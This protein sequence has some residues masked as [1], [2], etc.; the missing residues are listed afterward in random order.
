MIQN[1]R[2]ANILQNELWWG[3]NWQAKNWSLSL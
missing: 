1:K 3:G 2:A